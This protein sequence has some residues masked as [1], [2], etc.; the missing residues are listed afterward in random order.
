MHFLFLAVLFFSCN[1][2]QNIELN[3]PKDFENNLETDWLVITEPYTKLFSDSSLDVPVSA[4]VRLGEIY[5]VEGRRIKYDNNKNRILWYKIEEGWIQEVSVKI[6]SNK[7][8]AA[9]ISA[10]VMKVEK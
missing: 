4:F 1:R 3:L 8:K 2:Y 5:K 6:A 10:E 9:T 7:A